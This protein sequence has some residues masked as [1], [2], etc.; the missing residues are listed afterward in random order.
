MAQGTQELKKWVCFFG[1]LCFWVANA[2][3]WLCFVFSCHRAAQRGNGFVLFF[4]DSGIVWVRFVF[5]W[6]LDSIWLCFAHWDP[7]FHS[8]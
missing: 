1:I 6:L 2:D 8:G 7:S 5:S 3:I 4:V